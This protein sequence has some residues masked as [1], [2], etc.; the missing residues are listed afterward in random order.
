MAGVEERG[1]P[2]SNRAGA[3]GRGRFEVTVTLFYD[4]SAQRLVEAVVDGW[5]E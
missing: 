3:G 2:R 1:S 5:W 4:G